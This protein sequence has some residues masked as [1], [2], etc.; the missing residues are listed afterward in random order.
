MPPQTPPGHAIEAGY[1]EM[2]P[3]DSVL[4]QLFWAPSASEA[5]LSQSECAG[6][7]RRAAT[8]PSQGHSH[9]SHRQDGAIADIYEASVD[10]A[11]SS[12][13]PGLW[14]SQGLF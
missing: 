11:S 7:P 13:G 8:G 5:G 6:F 9:L 4:P 3:H 14:L 12:F 2:L 10:P 1:A